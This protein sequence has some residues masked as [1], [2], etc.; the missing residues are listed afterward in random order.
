VA[1]QPPAWSGGGGRGD[2]RPRL[3]G[4]SFKEEKSGEGGRTRSF[5][6]HIVE[7]R[8]GK[9]YNLQ[10]TARFGH[11]LRGI[12]TEEKMKEGAW[13]PKTLSAPLWWDLAE[14]RLLK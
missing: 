7:W 10:E 6:P 2:Y 11:F 12:K 1:G 8:Q 9:G 14:A 13:D 4:A 5:R 3:K